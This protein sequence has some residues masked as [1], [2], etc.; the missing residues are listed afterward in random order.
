M[1]DFPNMPELNFLGSRLLRNNYAEL[2]EFIAAK[3]INQNQK[4]QK[5]RRFLDSTAEKT[6]EFVYFGMDFLTERGK[7]NLMFIFKR[8]KSQNV[9]SLFLRSHGHHLKILNH[10]LQII[11]A[12]QQPHCTFTSRHKQDKDGRTK[13]V[14]LTIILV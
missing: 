10:K 8:N 14:F 5:N 2:F 3:S 9:L 4:N 7:R 11:Y 1:K 13:S 6:V 12:K